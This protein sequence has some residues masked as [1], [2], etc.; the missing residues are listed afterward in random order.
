M[1]TSKLD[2]PVRRDY[3]PRMRQDIEVGVPGL[4]GSQ[5][6]GLTGHRVLQ[7]NRTLGTT[8]ITADFGAF[9]GAVDET[10]C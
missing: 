8:E 7:G 3:Q 10:E 5:Y 1:G 4:Q 2:F 6:S 9:K